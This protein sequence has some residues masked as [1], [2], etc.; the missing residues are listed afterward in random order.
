[1][2]RFVLIRL[3]LVALLFIILITIAS[4]AIVRIWPYKNRENSNPPPSHANFRI[5]EKEKN[6]GMF[7]GL[8]LSGGGSRA[9]NF[10]TAVMLELK[11]LGIL[12]RVDFISSVSGGSL[13][14]AYYALEGYKGIQFNDPEVMRLMGRDFTGRWIGRWFLPQNIVR[15]WFTDFTRTDIMCQVFDNNL[16]HGATY[17][18]LKSERPK[19]IINAT[20]DN[21]SGP[22]TFTDED[23][24]LIDSSLRNYSVARAV[25]VSSAFPGVFQSVTLKWYPSPLSYLHLYDGGPVDN[26]GVNSLIEV[27]RGAAREE[28][29]NESAVEH[30]PKECVVIS[31]DATPRYLDRNSE[32]AHIREFIDYFFDRNA[33][34]SVDAML[35]SDR[36][37]ILQK[38]GIPNDKIDDEIFETF[39]ID[40]G[41]NSCQ[42]WH[43]ALRHLPQDDPLGIQVTTIET[44]FRID[45]SDQ[46]ALI[47]AAKRLVQ[48][49]VEKGKRSEKISFLF[50]HTERKVSE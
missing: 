50:S 6:D 39:S 41:N 30:F 5:E 22:F 12:D 10:A 36:R 37:D 1:M 20:N 9:A 35:L 49:G 29:E 44:D 42:F 2:R 19:L 31:V 27:L 38:V 16:F 21:V 33:L 4:C 34:H 40:G 7:I 14:A 43:I 23:F 46:Q 24:S 11:R 48:E 45:P 8:A 17:A 28:S 18:D 26:L 25:N 47:K 32:R 15:Y 3:S 13:P